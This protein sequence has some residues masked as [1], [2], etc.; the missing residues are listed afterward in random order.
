MEITVKLADIKQQN[1]RY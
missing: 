1:Q